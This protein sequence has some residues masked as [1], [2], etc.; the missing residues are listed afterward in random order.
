M[1]QSTQVPWS[2]RLWTI[3][4]LFLAIGLLPAKNGYALI[5][6]DVGHVRPGLPHPI[7]IPAKDV[8]FKMG[9]SAEVHVSVDFGGK[10]RPPAYVVEIE[11]EGGRAVGTWGGSGAINPENQIVYSNVPPGRYVIQG[12]PNPY[13]TSRHETTAPVTIDLK[14]GQSA[15]VT[16]LAR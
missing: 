16:L 12:H 2:R 5:E 7:S 3:A 14:A 6:G 11:A 15:Q 4:A 10:R 13:S 9:R 8:V 1:P